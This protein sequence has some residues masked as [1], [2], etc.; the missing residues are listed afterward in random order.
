[1]AWTEIT[2]AKYRR[3]AVRYASDLTDAEWA[4]VAL[5]LP[6]AS[7]LGRPRTTPIRSV[8]DAI[9]YIASTGCQWRQLPKEFPPYSTVQGYFYRWS[10]QGVF[11][12]INHLLVMA[13]REAAGREASPTA[14]VIDS[15]SVRTVES[16]GPRGFD[17][18]KKIKGRKRHIVTDTPSRRPRRPRSRCPGSRRG[19]GGPDLDPL[20]VP[21]AA[22]HLRRW[23]LRRRQTARGAQRQRHLDARDHQA[24][25]SRQRIHPSAASLGRRAHIRLAQPLPPPRE[26]L[27]GHHAKRNSLDLGRPLAN[28]HPPARERFTERAGILSQALSA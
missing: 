20:L 12:G 24:F 13:A 5:L 18:G 2:R 22:P 14:G 8:F 17:A 16:G 10:R 9:L 23:R 15:Q 25:R 7:P 26:G 19:A 3:E 4:L 28:H 27:R 6:P 1:M 11:A 21:V